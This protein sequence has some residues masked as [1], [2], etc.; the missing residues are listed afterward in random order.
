LA[1]QTATLP[2]DDQ[3]V[4]HATI[5]AGTCHAD[6]DSGA[7]LYRELIEGIEAFQAEGGEVSA[8]T[9]A[10]A[11]VQL[12]SAAAALGERLAP[13]EERVTALAAAFEG[14][15]DAIVV[16]GALCLLTAQQDCQAARTAMEELVASVAALA[17]A[18]PSALYLVRMLGDQVGRRAGANMIQ[19]QAAGSLAQGIVRCALPCPV[20]AAQAMEQ[21]IDQALAIRSEVDR[22]QALVDIFRSLGE[23]PAT[24]SRRLESA[25]SAAL[26]RARLGDARLERSVFAAAVEAMCAAG[27]PDAAERLARQAD[28]AP[29]AEELLSAVADHRQRLA[30]EELSDF[31]RAFLGIGDGKLAHAVLQSVKVENDSENLLQGLGELLVSEQSPVE[32]VRLLSEFLPQFAAPLRRLHGTS[33]IGRLI[34][35]VGRFDDAFV[36]AAHIVGRGG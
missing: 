15:N 9:V 22:A 33:E 21:V 17:E 10:E 13:L 12:A 32:R 18:P 25:L 8:S 28:D 23:G 11:I 31:E 19:A 27:D 1:E 30:L 4:I 26:R 14:A 7:L 3:I 29:L 24:W 20:E 34:A 16:R 36:E 35:E 5:S 2:V 6:P